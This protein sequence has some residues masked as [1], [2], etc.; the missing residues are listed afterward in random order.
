MIDSGEK[1]LVAMS[2]GVDSSVAASI[3]QTQGYE[4]TGVFLLLGGG[5]DDGDPGCGAARDA[6]DAQ[7]VADQLGIELLTLDWAREFEPIIEDFVQEYARGRTPNPCVRCNAWIKFGRLLELADQRGIRFVAT[8]HHVRIRRDESSERSEAGEEGCF[9]MRGAA[10]EKDQSYALFAVSRS[11]LPRLL[12]PVGKLAGKADVRKLAMDRGLCVND[13]GESQDICFAPRGDHAELLQRRCP[14]A[15]RPGSIVDSS[16]RELGRHEG[17]GRFTIGQ[18]RGLGVAAGVP[19]YV[20]AIDPRDA[21]VTIGP[22]EEVL[23]RKLSASDANW[24]CCP[25]TEFDAT[26]QIRYNHSGTPGRVRITGPGRFDVEF[27]EPVS[28]VTPGQ[29]A[30]VYRGDRLLG[31]GWID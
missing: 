17:Y 10:R 24:H 28:A 5:A 3:L 22:R 30:V 6:A 14:D 2:G 26:V 19:M 20:T 31:G 25:E 21:T 27:F 9:L 12:L 29:G 13:K 18:R 11:A 7:R 4:V 23:S 16:G 8:G 1:V 15:L